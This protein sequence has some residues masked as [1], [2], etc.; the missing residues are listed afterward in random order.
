MSSLVS[1][2]WRA[3]GLFQGIFALNI[4]SI[5]P[6]F[7]KDIYIAFAGVSLKKQVLFFCRRRLSTR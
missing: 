3:G 7:A 1:C 4:S 6:N 2:N 5:H